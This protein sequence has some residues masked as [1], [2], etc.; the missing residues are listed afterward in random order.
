MKS[1]P[2]STT[3]PSIVPSAQDSASEYWVA[4]VVRQM[5]GCSPSKIDSVIQANLPPRK[6]KWSQRPD[7][8]EIPGIEG[9][10]PYSIN[11][12]HGYELG[13]FK[14]NPLLHPE[15]AV[16]PNGK[17]AVPIAH[18]HQYNGKIATLT[19]VCFM[20]LALI[21]RFTRNFTSFQMSG[22]FLQ[23][24]KLMAN[25][26]IPPTAGTAF[27]GMTYLLLSLTGALLFYLY[28]QDKYDLFFCQ[29][30]KTTLYAYYLG[31]F[32]IFFC[33]K[34][35]FTKFINWIFF[36]KTSRENWRQTYG[37]LLIAESAL[38]LPVVI[39]GVFLNLPSHITMILAIL[40]ISI[41]KIA[42]LYKTFSIFL[43]KIYC[44]LHLLSYLCAL[45]IIPLLALGV[46]LIGI[47]E[48]LSLIF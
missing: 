30:P 22:F 31:C 27:I 18:Q 5:K 9:R 48:R 6:I 3:N 39:V 42:L 26:S 12:E 21:I 17:V 43:P 15:I 29:V 4:R 45:E 34:H 47:T 8:L 7:T 28:A 40:V 35:L 25:N 41:I 24:K 44:I 38:L 16:G 20:L 19:L 46:S 10:V 13:F 33:A 2:L 1:L 23:P 32:I 11:L 36:D 14:E 37:F